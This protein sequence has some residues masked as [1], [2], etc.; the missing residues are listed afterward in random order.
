MA[1]VRLCF[2]IGLATIASA[3]AQTRKPMPRPTSLPDVVLDCYLSFSTKT[4]FPEATWDDG[5]FPIDGD[6]FEKPHVRY[7]L[8][9]ADQT[10][11]KVIEDPTRP[12]LRKEHGV[13]VADMMR[14][15]TNKH[16]IVGWRESDNRGGLVLYTLSFDDLL[17]S[18]L[19]VAAKAFGPIAGV[20]LRVMKCQKVSS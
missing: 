12:A 4:P 1:P 5:K 16:S 14:D 2:L 10:V 6:N 7:R 20:T 8:Q 19:E 9:V 3:T 18:V 15:F 13:R 11:L 17:F